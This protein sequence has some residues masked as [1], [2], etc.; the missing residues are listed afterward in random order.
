MVCVGV[1]RDTKTE[2]CWGCE[3]LQNGNVLGL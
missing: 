2:M 1:V 3:G